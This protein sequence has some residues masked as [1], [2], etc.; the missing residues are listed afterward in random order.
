MIALES[1]TTAQQR[2]CDE[3]LESNLRHLGV[4]DSSKHHVRD[5]TAGA[6]F[7]QLP[8]GSLALTADGAVLGA[9][10]QLDFRRDSGPIGRQD[11]SAVVVF[12]LGAGHTVRDLLAHCRGPVI[13]YDPDP[14]VVRTVLQAG[15]TD[16]G[17]VKLSCD[18]DELRMWWPTLSRG[19]STAVVVATPGY[20]ERY[21]ESYAMLADALGTLVRS[22]KVNE[23]TLHVRARSWVDHVV[24]NLPQLAGRHPFGRLKG[25]Y[26]NVPAFIVGAGPSLRRNAHLLREAASKG[27]VFALNSSAS[28]LASHDAEPQVV[29]SLEAANNA[30]QLETLPWIDSVNRAMSLTAHP[31][32]WAIPR[33]HVLPYFE[34]MAFFGQLGQLLGVEPTSVAGSVSTAAFS[35][36]ESLGCNP[37]VF[38]GQDLA[39]TE[40]KV[41]AQ[42][43]EIENSRVHVDRDSGCIRYEWCDAAKRLYR[44]IA[45]APSGERLCEVPEWGG[46]GTV[47][48]SAT[49]NLVR[50]WMESR[51]RQMREAG[52]ERRLINATEGGSSIPGFEEIPLSDVLSGMQ[53]ASITSASMR[54]E[55]AGAGPAVAAD[56]IRGWLQD[57]ALAASEAQDAADRLVAAVAEATVAVQAESPTEVSQAYAA[58]GAAERDL[59][60][61]VRT[62]P[63][64]DGWCQAGIDDIV[65]A[66]GVAGMGV[67]D[68]LQQ[69]RV[70]LDSE[71]AMARVIGS[72]AKSLKERLVKAST[73]LDSMP[74][75]ARR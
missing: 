63:L 73:E 48:T 9:R 47:V 8:D 13:V 2:L 66:N 6:Q 38:L 56:A 71:L 16:L 28:V 34:Q 15:P 49:W 45:G 64:L 21:A 59:K 10:P 51:A 44:D 4:R 60:R 20:P 29:V 67:G 26:R 42:G 25:R 68:A 46:Q 55:A 7:V 27:I 57:Q 61:C 32:T 40:G 39:F 12:G 11:E 18:F 74:R 17:G 43:T 41:H 5:A 58:L 70:G 33:G 69:A 22:A 19:S 54:E 35:L 53:E 72:E 65:K 52:D 50:G 37:I 30:S 31:A 3:V 36:A 1:W 75:S 62:Q 24:A 23:C 14:S